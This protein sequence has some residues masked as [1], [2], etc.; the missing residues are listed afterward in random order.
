MTTGAP[1]NINEQAGL[2]RV[3]LHPTAASHR[4]HLLDALRGIAALLILFYH[5][6]KLLPFYH[7]TNLLPH[8]G[9]LDTYLAVDFFFCLSGFVIAFSYEQRLAEALS[10]KNFFAARVIRLYPTYLLGTL[11]GLIALLADHHYHLDG[12]DG[13][14]LLVMIGLQFAMLPSPH[15]L[16][17][18]YLFPLDIAAWSLFYE[19]LANFAFASLVRMKLAS[20]WMLVILALL[21]YILLSFSVV[22]LGSLDVGMFNTWQSIYLGIAR[23]TFS[24]LIGVLVFRLFRRTEPYR[25]PQALQRVLASAI[26]VALI[27]ILMSSFAAWASIVFSLLTIAVLFPPL[28]YLGALTA[29]PESWKGVCVFLGNISYPVYVLQGIFLF[30][31]YKAHVTLAATQHIKLFIACLIAAQIVT[32]QLSVK[33]YDAPLRKRLTKYY[34]SIGSA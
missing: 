18:Y 3:A 10:L 30:G 6:M 32:A 31:F 26:P 28:V 33:F 12:K 5:L 24:F 25:P 14:R 16:G 13:L 15:L 9:S 29:I 22:P 21:S 4:F 2:Q 34:N 7:A 8:S 27:F 20:S 17:N 23:V 11:L 1:S 19:L